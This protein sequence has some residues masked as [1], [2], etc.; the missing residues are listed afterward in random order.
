MHLK[1][2]F[3]NACGHSSSFGHCYGDIQV[4]N[5][6]TSYHEITSY[7]AYSI[8]FPTGTGI[9][10]FTTASNTSSTEIAGIYNSEGEYSITKSNY[11][12]NEYTG[13]DFAIIW[14]TS[15]TKYS[16]CSFIGNKGIYLFF[17]EPK[18]VYSC[19]FNNNN[20]IRA[21]NNYP[22]TFD[23]VEQLDSFISH[24]STYYCI[25][26]KTEE[27][28]VDSY[29]KYQKEKLKLKNIKIIV[30]KVYKTPFVRAVTL[31]VLK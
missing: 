22:D 18:S 9:I 3:H 14:C 21:I 8:D 11:L 26:A 24:Y 17:P 15:S 31:S 27:N 12:N 7:A 6:N 23:S 10:N 20:V 2:Q 19:F 16:S 29:K 1:V 25:A 28:K 13:S 30:K 5:M 4:S